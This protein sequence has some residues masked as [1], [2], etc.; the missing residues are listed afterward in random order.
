MK[1]IPS[2]SNHRENPCLTIG[3]QLRGC[4]KLVAR[5][6]RARAAIEAAFT[7][8]RAPQRKLVRL[9]LI[10]AEALAW[11][12]PFPHLVFP[13]LAEEK[14]RAVMVWQSRQAALLGAGS[15]LAFA[16]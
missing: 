5:I 13:T 2:E 6:E 8:Q 10:E 9:A 4:P 3:L 1:P 14:V 15:E 7:R 11:Q 12:T 16:A